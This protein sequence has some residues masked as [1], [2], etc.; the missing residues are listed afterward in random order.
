MKNSADAVSSSFA[1]NEEVE[2]NLS[3]IELDWSADDMDFSPRLHMLA[4]EN[5]REDEYSVRRCPFPHWT[6]NRQMYESQIR[7]LQK[8]STSNEEKKQ[9]LKETMREIVTK[10]LETDA[11]FAWLINYNPMMTQNGT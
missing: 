9:Y 6:V 4:E 3:D 5:H 8:E 11:F 10:S 1:D 7:S 2:A